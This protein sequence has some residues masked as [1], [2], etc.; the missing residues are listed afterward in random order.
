MLKLIFPIGFCILDHFLWLEFLGC[1]GVLVHLICAL[2]SPNW[3]TP[4][5]Q[6]WLNPL[7]TMR[8]CQPHFLKRISKTTIK[9]H[10]THWAYCVSVLEHHRKFTNKAWLIKVLAVQVITV[11][12]FAGK[13]TRAKVNTSW[14]YFEL[15]VRLIPQLPLVCSESQP[16]LSQ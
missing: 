7:W 11:E 9:I 13:V 16:L 6:Q 15:Y 12:W 3:T 5:T 4:C 14:R 2:F 8:P 1:V 10:F